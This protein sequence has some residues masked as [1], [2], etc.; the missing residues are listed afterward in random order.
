MFLVL[1]E[2]LVTRPASYFTPQSYE[3]FPSQG[4][5]PHHGAPQFAVPSSPSQVDFFRRPS[6][7]ELEERDYR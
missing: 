4:Y 7:E 2:T 1:P 5:Y 6:A 3:Y